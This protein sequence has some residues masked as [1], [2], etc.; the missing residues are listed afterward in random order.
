MATSA[1]QHKPALKGINI[2]L[3]KYNPDL[4]LKLKQSY[5]PIK[6]SPVVSKEQD[7]PVLKLFLWDKT[8]GKICS[9]SEWESCIFSGQGNLLTQV[10]LFYH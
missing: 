9:F 1:R 8:L 5:S 10:Y 3:W 7:T 4:Q 6:I 2:V